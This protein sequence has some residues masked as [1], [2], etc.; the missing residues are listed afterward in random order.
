MYKY[1]NQFCYLTFCVIWLS[2]DCYSRLLQI[3][4]RVIPSRMEKAKKE[5]V[6]AERREMDL[7]VRYAKLMELSSR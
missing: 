3:E 7:Q 2:I 5:M 1:I 4:S 6:D